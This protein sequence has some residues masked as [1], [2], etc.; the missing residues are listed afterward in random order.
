M[1]RE[2]LEL[3]FIGSALFG[4]SLLLLSSVGPGMHLRIHVPHIRIPH[5]RIGHADDATLMPIVLGFLAMFGIGGLF[6]IAL[7]ANG[8]GQALLALTAGA[9]GASLVMGIFSALHRAQGPEPTALRDLVGRNARVVV[10]IGRDMRGTVQ[11][12][13]DGAVH[14]LPASSDQDIPRGRE[15][16]I[17][18]V[19]GMAVTVRSLPPP[20]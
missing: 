7:G 4:S 19:H 11:L 6:G 5:L 2:A 17:V 18:A 20:P 12:T 9:A 8:A 15:V 13:Y 16:I 10:S 14:S 3:I 1:T